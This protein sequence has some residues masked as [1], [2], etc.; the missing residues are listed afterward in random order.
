MDRGLFGR[1]GQRKQVARL[2][3]DR[4]LRG[5]RQFAQQGLHDG[6]VEIAERI[7]SERG[8]IFRRV[9]L[10]EFF[11]RRADKRLLFR[12]CPDDQFAAGRI[13]RQ[14][15]PGHEFVQ[16]RFKH[17]GGAGAPFGEA[18]D[19]VGFEPWLFFGRLGSDAGDRLLDL[20]VFG[21]GGPDKQ[22]RAPSVGEHPRAGKQVLEHFLGAGRVGR[23]DRI[24][25][26]L[27]LA[28][29]GRP[30]ALELLEDAG[31]GLVVQRGGPD[32]QFARLHVRQDDDAGQFP[33]Q[34]LQDRREPLLLHGGHGVNDQLAA[35]LG[36]GR[37][38]LL[39]AA[40]DDLL[41]C[42]RADDDQAIVVGVV[43]HQGAGH[44]PG[45]HRLQR[46][47]VVILERIE[48][49]L[50]G[51]TGGRLAFDRGWHEAIEGR[52]D[53]CMFA[54]IGEHHHV[55]G[56]LVDVDLHAGKERFEHHLQRV[57]VAVRDFV[58]LDH[59][60]LAGGSRPAELFNHRLD[61]LVFGPGG[62][63][64]QAVVAAVDMD[65]GARN[66]LLERVEKRIGRRL[67]RRGRGGRGGRGGGAGVL[68]ALAPEVAGIAAA[69][70]I[71]ASA[72]NRD[73][74]PVL[75]DPVPGAAV[76]VADQARVS[77][78]GRGGRAGF[79]DRVDFQV[80]IQLGRQ[81]GLHAFEHF[82]DRG[83]EVRRRVR[84]QLA[85]LGVILQ[86]D[87][88][89]HL[90]DNVLDC[91]RIRLGDWVDDQ[92]GR[93]R[94]LLRRLGLRLLFFRLGRLGDRLDHGADRPH[95]A[96]HVADHKLLGRRERDDLAV[97]P[98]ERLDLR[99]D[100]HDVLAPE[101]KLHAHQF[102]LAAA[103]EFLQGDPGDQPVGYAL[104]EIMDDQHL[105]AADQRE[106]FCLQ[107]A[108]EDVDCLFGRVLFR[109][110]VVEGARRRVVDHQGEVRLLGEPFEHIG[111]E[112]EAEIEPDAPPLQ[113]VEPVGALVGGEH[114]GQFLLG[115]EHCSGAPLRVGRGNRRRTLVENRR[116]PGSLLVGQ[117]HPLGDLRMDQ[118]GVACLGVVGPWRP[119]RWSARRSARAIALR[120]SSPGAAAFACWRLAWRGGWCLGGFGRTVGRRRRTASGRRRHGG[121]RWGRRGGGRWGRGRR[122]WLLRACLLRRRGSGLLADGQRDRAKRNEQR[123]RSAIG[124]TARWES[125]HDVSPGG[126]SVFGE[127][128][129][130]D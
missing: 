107:D 100:H 66:H 18:A 21:G 39:D 128:C 129:S 60:R 71:V 50:R 78:A 25:D 22:F 54:R 116:D 42:G 48:P 14:R 80:A 119:A 32:G 127:T 120:P 121:G 76:A 103:I 2:G 19:R 113:L 13:K 112:L 123:Q 10:P 68:R 95:H 97:R 62:E 20:L 82:G 72:A 37:L 57:G 33:D 7:D 77:A 23:F 16:V 84:V 111:P 87:V 126:V 106:A 8:G 65:F 52:L 118:L 104:R 64:H 43:G 47:R 115:L 93:N 73:P 94:L 86:R 85:P 17:P 117:S 98:Q 6:R 9:A 110:A 70:G 34:V 36:P 3:V 122:C 90:A 28:L 101:R 58:D 102:E 44:Q 75:I 29:G 130:P 96:G 109:V 69:L 31:D 11:D 38:E 5:G 1:H 30:L 61:D 45:K 99:F 41:V 15:G 89:D 27:E 124:E 4:Q 53:R 56:G 88:R 114:V 67:R 35:I 63:S 125:G 40:A 91:L 81:I 92:L 105:V 51:R 79:L 108:V 59:R 46:R 49:Q 24:G 74:A 26:K 12:R 83:L 55:V